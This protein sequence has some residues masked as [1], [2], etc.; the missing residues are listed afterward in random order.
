MYLGPGWSDPLA[1]ARVVTWANPPNH[2]PQPTN[3]LVNFV[4]NSRLEVL[5]EFD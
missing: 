5:F 4:M 3:H 1:A 2:N